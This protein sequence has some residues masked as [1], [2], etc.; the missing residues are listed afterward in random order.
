MMQAFRR[1]IN[2]LHTPHLLAQCAVLQDLRT[3]TRVGY[4]FAPLHAP[5]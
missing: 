4:L 5:L 2:Q 3:Y 1:S